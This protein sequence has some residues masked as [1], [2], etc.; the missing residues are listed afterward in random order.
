MN[1][2]EVS[3]LTLQISPHSFG[4]TM[5]GI[6]NKND[7]LNRP[8]KTKQRCLTEILILILLCHANQS[9]VKSKK[10]IFSSR[11]KANESQRAKVYMNVPSNSCPFCMPA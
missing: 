11:E 5:K 8:H 7:L 1:L 2:N 3:V 10:R 6:K 9:G 4:E